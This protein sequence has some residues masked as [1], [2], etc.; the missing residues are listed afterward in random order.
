M[1]KPVIKFE[2]TTTVTYKP[3]WDI[4]LNGEKIGTIT[5]DGIYRK[6]QTVNIGDAYIFGHESQAVTKREILWMLEEGQLSIDPA[7]NKRILE[8][9]KAADKERAEAMQVVDTVSHDYHPYSLIVA[10]R[11]N[12]QKNYAIR[13]IERL[14]YA[15]VLEI[16][17]GTVKKIELN[18][19]DTGARANTDEDVAE[20]LTRMLEAVKARKTFLAIIA[21]YEGGR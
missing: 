10:T 1:K 15:P 9:K 20:M 6:K 13:T 16:Y 7:E 17:N 3:S 21:D 18:T 12:G 19:R 4:L 11:R 8:A 2:S 14:P 5:T